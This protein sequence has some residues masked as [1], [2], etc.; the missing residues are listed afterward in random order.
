MVKLR[1]KAGNVGGGGGGGGGG[2]EEEEEDEEEE[3]EEEEDIL[4]G[5]SV[6]TSKFFGMIM[7][8]SSVAY[9]SEFVCLFVCF[10]GA[11]TAEFCG[12][13]LRVLWHK[14]LSS[15]AYTSEFYDKYF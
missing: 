8:L 11:Y 3:E 7:P 5:L 14:L 12:I 15:V 4:L 10:G 13:Y 9:T 2:E 1:D 6:Y